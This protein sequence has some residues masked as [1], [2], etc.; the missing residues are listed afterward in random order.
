MY[1]MKKHVQRKK[2]DHAKIQI[3]R[4]NF[5]F[6]WA[7]MLA[8]PIGDFRCGSFDFDNLFDPVAHLGEHEIRAGLWPVSAVRKPVVPHTH[9]NCEAAEDAANRRVVARNNTFHPAE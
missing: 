5:Y 3:L 4:I 6:L 1:Q 9:L 8:L 7:T 2:E